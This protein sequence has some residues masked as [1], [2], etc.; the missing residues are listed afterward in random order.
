MER[1]LAQCSPHKTQQESLI[2]E[3]KVIDCGVVLINEMNDKECCF[4]RVTWLH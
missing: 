2:K 1:M 4:I 3:L